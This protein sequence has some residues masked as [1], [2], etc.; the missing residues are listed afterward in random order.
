L[1]LALLVFWDLLPSGESAKPQKVWADFNA[2]SRALDIYREGCG[3][4]PSNEEGL[5]A[6]LE[7]PSSHPA[8]EQWKQLAN[9]APKDPWMND[10]QYR[11]HGSGDSARFEI[12]TP[13]KDGKPGTKDDV[14]SLDE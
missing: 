14:S 12:W 8:P 9:K 6:L 4:F 7:C 3:C 5:T 11:L 2:I 10:Y 13:G 1:I